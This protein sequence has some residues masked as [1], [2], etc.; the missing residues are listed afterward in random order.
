MNFL[1]D[2]TR[3]L[4]ETTGHQLN[5]MSIQDDIDMLMESGD[6]TTN[7]AATEKKKNILKRIIAMIKQAIEKAISFI[8]NIPKMVKDHFEKQSNTDNVYPDHYALLL[9]HEYSNHIFVVGYE[10]V[11]NELKKCIGADGLPIITNSCDMIVET[12]HHRFE[13]NFETLASAADVK[14]WTK[15]NAPNNGWIDSDLT[16]FSSIPLVQTYSDKALAILKDA[17]ELMNNI[18]NTISSNKIKAGALSDIQYV[19]TSCKDILS[20]LGKVQTLMT[21]IFHI[22]FCQ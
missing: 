8:T 19:I 10:K 20:Y 3:C 5:M 21:P 14:R 13:P 18:M 16:S 7:T 15:K 2:E 11:L 6:E 12:M 4:L 1:L 22:R 9:A 17:D